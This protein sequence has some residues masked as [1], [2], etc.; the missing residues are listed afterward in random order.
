MEDN[1]KKAEELAMQ[2]ILDF[3]SPSAVAHVKRELASYAE[4]VGSHPDTETFVSFLESLESNDP[5]LKI[6]ESVGLRS[7]S[8]FLGHASTKNCSDVTQIDTER[9]IQDAHMHQQVG[10]NFINN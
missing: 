1:L 9:L 4:K 3:L 7:T 10:L 6:T 8:I 5:S 2:N